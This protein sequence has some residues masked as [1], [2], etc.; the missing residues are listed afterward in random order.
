MTVSTPVA[1]RSSFL[2]DPRLMDVAAALVLGFLAVIAFSIAFA[3]YVVSQM[4]LPAAQAA[5]AVQLGSVTPIVLAVGLAHVLAIVLIARP[6]RIGRAFVAMAAGGV[7]VSTSAGAVMLASGVDVL[8]WAGGSS[9]SLANG[10]GIAL[11][12][13]VVYGSVALI[14]ARSAVRG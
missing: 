14:A 4:D 2:P 9:Q 5:Q 7:A 6:G 10:V 12:T 1:S 3:T 13:T 11:V 8:G